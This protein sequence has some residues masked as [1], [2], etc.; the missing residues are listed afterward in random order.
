MIYLHK[1]IPVI[2]LPVGC[3]CLLLFCSIAFNKRSLVFFSLI[4]L[5]FCS[6]PLVSD[7]LMREV[8]KGWV[9]VD[10]KSVVPAS[11]IVVLSSGRTIAPGV[12]GISEWGDAD[13]FFAGVE[14]FREGKAPFLL[15]TGGWLPWQTEGPL[16]GDVLVKTAESVGIPH[17]ALRT[18]GRVVNTAE[19]AREVRRVLFSLPEKSK[20]I[21]LVTSAF[22]MERAILVFRKEGM[23][24]EPF[25]VDFLA[26][27]MDGIGLLDLVP[28]GSALQKTEMAIREMYGR[29]YYYFIN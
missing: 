29:I 17:E 16:E 27:R 24:V 18:T 12:Q 7:W 14:L 6:I 22:H 26:K 5:Y 25:A 8:E 19:E 9:R 20:K 11:A 1:I 28:S 15:F 3:L 21:I 23:E 2:F 4:L 10:P 13:R